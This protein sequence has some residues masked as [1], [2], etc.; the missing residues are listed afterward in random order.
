L[1]GTDDDWLKLKSKVTNCTQLFNEIDP[2]NNFS[3]WSKHFVGIID[4]L[5]VTRQYIGR[6]DLPE[7][8]KHFWSTIITHIP[9]GSG[10][11]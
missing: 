5:I 4:W 11:E 8:V 7:D 9:F 10:D 6:D 1:T 2:N 3:M